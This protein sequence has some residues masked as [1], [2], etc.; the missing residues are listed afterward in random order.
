MPPG[1]K[2]V[3][4]FDNYYKR[5]WNKHQL[6]RKLYVDIYLDTDFFFHQLNMIYN[7]FRSG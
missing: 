3:R 5:L 2:S 4:L 7:K 1:E 6:I